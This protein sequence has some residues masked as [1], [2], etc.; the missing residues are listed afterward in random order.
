[1]TPP[2]SAVSPFACILSGHH[3]QGATRETHPV[4]SAE[5]CMY[6]CQND[7]ACNSFDYHSELCNFK[8]DPFSP[9]V[10]SDPTYKAGPK[11]C[12]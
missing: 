1:M 3:A 11:F 6:A 2:F 9:A 10:N 8:N 7:A 5:L 12:T 4:A